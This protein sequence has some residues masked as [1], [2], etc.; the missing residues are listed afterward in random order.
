MGSA[1]RNRGAWIAAVL[2]ALAVG[3]WWWRSQGASAGEEQAGAGSGDTAGQ[4]TSAAGQG[5]G[6]AVGGSAAASAPPDMLRPVACELDSLLEEYRR[7]KAS[8][9]YR[10]YVREQLQGILE[11]LP[12]EEL[13]ALVESEEDPEVLELVASLWVT[14]FNLT[15]EFSVLERM[16]ARAERERDP[17]RRAAMVRSLVAT[18]DPSSELLAGKES[19][20]NTYR[21]LVNDPAPEVRQAVVDNLT[22]EAARN[23]GRFQGVAEQAVALAAAAEEP[24]TAAGLLQASALEAVRP[25]ALSTV[26]GMLESSKAPEVRA[27]AAKALGT[28]PSSELRPTLELLA[29][30]YKAEPDRSVRSALLES[31]SRLGLSQA[32]SYL[33]RLKGVDSALD[34]E[35]DTWLRLLAS[36]PP[37]GFLLQQD[38]LAQEHR[39]GGG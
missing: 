3:L 39:Q 25:Q 2:L 22:A 10:R 4:V 1:I 32:P 19:T 15:Q 20:R 34:G 17:V 12:P 33:Q 36:N 35:I 21:A 31:L 8:P 11:S 13:W 28:V 18:G 38:K 24:K 29:A 6:P 16:V 9:A 37:N 26:R 14:R 30:R 27:A 5:S 23:F 7:G